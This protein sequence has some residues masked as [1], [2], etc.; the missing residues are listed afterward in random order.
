MLALAIIGGSA[1]CA[2]KKPPSR[3]LTMER[4]AKRQAEKGIQVSTTAVLAAVPRPAATAAAKPTTLVSAGL[5]PA[6]RSAMAL[7]PAGLIQGTTVSAD[8]KIHRIYDYNTGTRDPFLPLIGT[9]VGAGGA[10]EKVSLP[11]ATGAFNLNVLTLRGIVW[12]GR[13]PMAILSDTAGGSYVVRD[14]RVV[15][16][17]GKEV[18]GVTGIIKPKSV[19][20]T[21]ASRTVRELKM[22][23]TEGG[24][25]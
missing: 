2:K 13:Q 6:P 1:G 17:H 12:S 14:G 15:D 4:W 21:T 8:V 24:A 5:K 20:L 11:T 22:E 3:E 7:V 19:I 16:S 23:I 9:G 18:R 10:S 25:K